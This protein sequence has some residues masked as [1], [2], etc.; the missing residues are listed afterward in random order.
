MTKQEFEKL[1]ERARTSGSTLKDFLKREG[2]AYSTYNY[3]RKKIETEESKDVILPMAP[4]SFREPH[5]ESFVAT[6]DCA[7]VPGVVVAFPN[8][9]KAHFGAGSEGV[10]MKVL[11]A[12]MSLDN[13][14]P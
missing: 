8:G 3:W 4:I 14:L 6:L 5:R 10:L 2:I 13:V 1:S 7:T 12:S 9:I 11:D